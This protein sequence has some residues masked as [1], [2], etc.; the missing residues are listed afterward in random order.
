MIVH[1]S[2][3]APQP[4]KE[5]MARW[6]GQ[7]SWRAG[8]DAMRAAVADDPFDEWEATEVEGFFLEEV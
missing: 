8:I 5:G 2:I 1:L 7:A 4:G 3:H 6:E